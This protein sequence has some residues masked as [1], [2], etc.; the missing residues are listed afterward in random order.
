[1]CFPVFFRIGDL[2]IGYFFSLVLDCVAVAWMI[3]EQLCIFRFDRDG[4][5]FGDINCVESRWVEIWFYPF[6]SSKTKESAFFAYHLLS[7][8]LFVSAGSVIRS[9]E[10]AC[11]VFNYPLTLCTLS[12]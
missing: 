11:L 3:G 8:Q 9:V 7:L 10:L 2:D 4:R 6:F 5:S 1:G 12:C